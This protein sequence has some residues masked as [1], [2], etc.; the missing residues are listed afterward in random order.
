MKNSEV[1]HC[2]DECLLASIANS[3]SIKDDQND[4]LSW[5]DKTDP[6]L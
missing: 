1:S 6:W 4:A 3:T 2:S 5:D